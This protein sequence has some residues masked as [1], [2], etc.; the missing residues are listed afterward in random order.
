[1][2]INANRNDIETVKKE[3]LEKFRC[4]TKFSILRNKLNPETSVKEIEKY[5][6]EHPKVK[7]DFSD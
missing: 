4:L 3:D 2:F 5:I 1:M 6:E 7:V